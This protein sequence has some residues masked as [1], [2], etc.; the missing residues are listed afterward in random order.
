MLRLDA[1]CRERNVLRS[2]VAVEVFAW[3]EFRR[4]GRQEENFDEFGVLFQLGPNLLAAMHPQVVEDQEHF[5]TCIADQ[6]G[7]EANQHRCRQ[8]FPV[9]HEAH[10]ALVGDR[11][12]HVRRKVA[13]RYML[14]RHLAH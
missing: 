8:C 12:N 5:A 3:I 11:R 4:I 10:F 1:R 7:L 9:Q 14:H 6:A 13:P 2:T